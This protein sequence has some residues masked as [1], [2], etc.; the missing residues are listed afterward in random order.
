MITETKMEISTSLSICKDYVLLWDIREIVCKLKYI[1][2][3]I[4]FKWIL[5]IAIQGLFKLSNHPGY[6]VFSRTEN[7]QQL[8]VRFYYLYI[9]ASLSNTT[10]ISSQII[11]QTV[12]S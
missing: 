2:N 12:L 10:F 8:W 5:I 11:F 6:I 1:Y 3:V 7:S 9:F 4:E